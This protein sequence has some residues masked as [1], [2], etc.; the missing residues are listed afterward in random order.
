MIDLNA[1]SYNSKLSEPLAISFHTFY[2]RKNVL[3]QLHY[4]E[5]VGIGE[6]APF[7]PITGDDQQEVLEQAKLLQTLSLDPTVDGVEELHAY[8]DDKNITSHTLRAAV[9]FAY[10]DLLG[11]LQQA[12]VYKLY[13]DKPMLADN[14][15]TIFVKATPE[16]TIQDLKNLY[17]R[18]PEI[19]IM[20]IKLKG[21]GDIERAKVIKSASPDH[22]RFT[23]DANQGFSDEKEAVR[24]LNEIQK[25][26]G[27]VIL[28][29]EPCPKGE[30]E[31]LKYVKDNV[32]NML[33][34]A[35]E[36]AATVEDAKSVI[37]HNAAHGINI[38]LEKAGGIWPSKQIAKMCI[39][40]DFKI[41][42]GC[43]LEGPFALAA[44]AHF[45]VSTPN[46]VL[47]ELDGDNELPSHTTTMIPTIKGKR[48]PFNTPGFGIALDTKKLEE[49]TKN[50]I[51]IYEKVV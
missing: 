7:K 49:L 28:V 45:A 19:S 47:A 23:V 27:E 39:E 1:Y 2:Y 21:E 51:L 36:S 13:S 43:M 33:V 38:K 24:V 6:A 34:F 26:L 9:D 35:D 32:E 12:P 5:M 3:I 50:K 16:E 8:M 10:H 11:K 31:K 29:E 40:N 18:E 37:E 20:K 14:C 17:T 42:V 46:I 15:L 4:Q 48:A 22:M 30:L 41:M 25:I 44:G